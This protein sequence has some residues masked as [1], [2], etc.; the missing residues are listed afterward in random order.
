MF[1]FSLV[2]LFI[3]LAIRTDFGNDFES[4]RHTYYSLSM[5][6]QAWGQN[7]KL[8]VYLNSISPTF[9]FFIFITSLIYI[10]TI[11]WFICTYLDNK[12][13]SFSL[14]FLLINPYL[15]LI[16]ASALRQMLA[17]CLVIFAFHFL[18]NRKKLLYVLIILAA[19]EFHP[20]AVA[21]LSLVVVPFNKRPSTML[22]VTLVFSL[23]IMLSSSV[24][25]SLLGFILD[26]LPQYSHYESGEGNSL[27]SVLLSF[28]IFLFILIRMNTVD[29]KHVPFVNMTLISSYLS[30]LAF[31]L[32]MLTRFAIYFDVFSIVGMPVLFSNLRKDKKAFLFGLLVLAIYILRYYSFFTNNLWQPFFQY[33][34]VIGV[35]SG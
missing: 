13:Y 23:P 31:N 26:F 1:A 20:S 34:S 12:Y 17:M 9:E 2:I 6:L 32:G 28:I 16:H 8:F 10:V 3:F 18:I 5:N 30:L 7:D 4:Y 25:S 29:D 24:F 11:G 19:S 33:N 22:K 21:L 14:F 15:F 35:T 27:R